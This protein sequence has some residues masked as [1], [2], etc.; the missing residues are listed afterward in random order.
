MLL[1]IQILSCIITTVTLFVCDLSTFLIFYSLMF[2]FIEVCRTYHYI[3]KKKGNQTMST[4]FRDSPRTLWC[5]P[6]I[7]FAK[8]FH[9]RRHAVL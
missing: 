3:F 7:K 4:N 2:H 5:L 6:I 9:V 1:E 8:I